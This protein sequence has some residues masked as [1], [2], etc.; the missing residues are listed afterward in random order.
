[1]SANSNIEWTD[2]TWNPCLGCSK[3]SPG[4]KRCYAIREV[5]RMAGNPNPK[6]AAANAGLTII[7][8][9]EPNWTGKVRL[10]PERLGIP[11]K[12]RKPTRHFV[13]SLSDLFHEELPD[14]AIDQV[15]GAM[16]LATRHTFQVL[17]K[18]AE[19]MVRWFDSNPGGTWDTST[20]QRCLTAAESLVG[21][22]LGSFPFPMPH[23]WL[24]VSVES[25]DYLSRIDDLRR[26]PAA[27]RF[28]S[29]EP[30]LEDLGNIGDYL[31][32]RC[33]ECGRFWKR[34]WHDCP[35]PVGCDG[36]P[37]GGIDWVIVGGESGKGARPVHPD[38]VRSIRDQCIAAGVPFFFKQWGEWRDRRLSDGEPT[39]IC[40]LMTWKGRSGTDLANAEDGGDTWME[41]FRQEENGARIGWPHLG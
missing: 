33:P 23:V 15:F 20:D 19:R 21:H 1:M 12:R 34:G 2:D 11:L 5:H 27:V 24:G 31:R 7:Q 18:R 35:N 37:S 39:R 14:E 32:D 16:G 9:G 10:I 38:W 29:L 8:G 30:L 41:K 40:R 3:T 4:C 22:R 36:H 28:L 13:N 17:T 6:I 25:R 26:T